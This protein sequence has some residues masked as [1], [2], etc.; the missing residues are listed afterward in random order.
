MPLDPTPRR[1]RRVATATVCAAA[2]LVTAGCSLLPRVEQGRTPT[3]GASASS[4]APPQSQPL[5]VGTPAPQQD[6]GA[7]PWDEHGALVVTLT[8]VRRVSD[9]LG[10][11]TVTLHAEEDSGP[12]W[13]FDDPALQ[14]SG[15]SVAEASK[16]QFLSGVGLTTAG[17]PTVFQTVTDGDEGCLCSRLP[18]SLSAGQTTAAFAYVTLPEAATSVD[19]TVG[20][21][22]PWTDVPV[23]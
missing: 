17:D 6:L 22:G 21:L 3:P 20:P 8:G 14:H 1:G 13:S 11:V 5:P 4:S 19:V 10:L 16:G 7:L 9:G 2:L 18:V 23:S 12:L 15:S